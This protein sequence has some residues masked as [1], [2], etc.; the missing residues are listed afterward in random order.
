MTLMKRAHQIFSF[1]AAFILILP[2]LSLASQSRVIQ[3]VDGHTII[4][5]YNGKY[6]KVALLY[7]NTPEP[8]PAYNKRN[9]PLGKIASD[10][11]E[12]RLKGKYVDLE[13]EGPFSGRYGSLLVYVYVDGVN[14]NLEL[15]KQGLS[16]YYTEYGSSLKYDKEFTE[17][18]AYARIH[19]LNIWGDPELTK[20][21]LTL[22]S[23]W[24]RHRSQK[25]SI[26][27]IVKRKT[28]KCVAD[29]N[30]KIF[31]RTGCE[32]VKDIDPQNLIEFSSRE[33]AIKS[34]RKPCKSCNP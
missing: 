26:P 6:E 34:G 14:L 17:A 20:R 27:V 30:S 24:D 13:F 33:E 22:K 25:S 3:I 15:V 11:T 8:V 29:K 5:D 12:R 18:E 2:L 1:V 10:Y 9:I 28:R 16:P 19:K 4:V 32:Y 21:Y 23:E 7:V 31:H